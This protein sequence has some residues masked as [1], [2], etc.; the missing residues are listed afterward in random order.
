[1]KHPPGDRMTLSIFVILTSCFIASLSSVGFTQP[2]QARYEEQERC[3]KRASEVFKAD[4]GQQIMLN[5]EGTLFFNYRNNYNAA[6]NKCFFLEI[7]KI[8]GYRAKTPYPATMYRLYDIDG[9]REYGSFYKRSDAPSPVDCQIL[10]K[11]CAS[12]AGW[13]LLIKRFMED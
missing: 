11:S 8:L 13:E 1:V 9:N 12:E 4:Y 10:G 6:L 3:G 2:T 7:T 5:Q